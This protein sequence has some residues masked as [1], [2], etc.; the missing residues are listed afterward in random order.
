MV[1]KTRPGAVRRPSRSRPQRL[2]SRGWQWI[3]SG[4]AHQ[5]L[6]T[7]RRS[8]ERERESRNAGPLS[9]PGVALP[10]SRRWAQEATGK[11]RGAADGWVRG[12]ADGWVRG[13]ADG[14]VCVKLCMGGE[15]GALAAASVGAPN[16]TDRRRSASDRRGSGCAPA[17]ACE[18]AAGFFPR[19][20]LHAVGTQLRG[21][22]GFSWYNVGPRTR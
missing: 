15:P 21:C 11:V 18:R 4:G 1:R 6:P 12:A 13:A 9:N 19:R 7:R 20:P 17:L 10:S 14:W 5:R 2:G 16:G 8:S 22:E 3:G